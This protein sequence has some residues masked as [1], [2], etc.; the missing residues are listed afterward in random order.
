MGHACWNIF[1]VQRASIRVSALGWRVAI[2]EYFLQSCVAVLL[3]WWSF[4]LSLPKEFLA[5]KNFLLTV[6]RDFKKSKIVSL[7]R[8]KKEFLELF[9]ELFGKFLISCREKRYVLLELAKYWGYFFLHSQSTL[10]T[11]QV[12]YE[13]HYRLKQVSNRVT[14]ELAV[15]R[16]SMFAKGGGKAA[17][18]RVTILLEGWTEQETWTMSWTCAFVKVS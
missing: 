4:G 2:W 17:D 16:C 3:Y 14:A 18:A 6:Y 9:C 12:R 11:T 7:A 8:L 10:S 1:K 5:N 13:L 15:I